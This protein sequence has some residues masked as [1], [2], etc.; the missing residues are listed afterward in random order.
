MI[1]ASIRRPLKWVREAVHIGSAFCY[2]FRRYLVYSSSVNWA[3][4]QQ[5]LRAVLTE[6]YH[7]IEKGL[8]LPNPRLAFGRRPLA[9][10]VALLPSYVRMYG[11]DEFTATVACVLRSYL[12]FNESAGVPEK[13]IPFARSIR[14][15]VAESGLDAE[16]GVR[17]V[18]RADIERA[19]LGVG[20]E[21]FLTRHSTRKFSA[22]PVTLD[23]VEWAARA[24]R[25]S[26]AVCNR[27]FSRLH[28]FSTRSTS[29]GC[30][31]SRAARVDSLTKSEDSP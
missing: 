14:A 22:V 4:G 3:D 13:D 10:I 25:Q 17:S 18:S 7:S 5:R 16:G 23:E 15:L 12:R 8:S 26:P 9:D 20:E 11:E 21:F 29:R 19:T 30:S 1:P 2:D 24:A 6:R 28:V 27:Q 31:R